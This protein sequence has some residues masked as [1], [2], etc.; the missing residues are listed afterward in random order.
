VVQLLQ[1]QLTQVAVVKAK[2]VELVLQ[3]LEVQE[4]LPME[5]SQLLELLVP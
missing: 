4:E 2:V 3:L 5:H 1:Q